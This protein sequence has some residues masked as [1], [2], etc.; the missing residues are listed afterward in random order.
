MKLIQLTDIHLTTPGE[1]IAGRD[2]NANFD[3]AL[4]HSLH[5]HPDAEAIVITGDLSDWGDEADYLRL[6]DRIAT[7]PVPVHLCIGNHD[8]RETFLRV[9]PD[10]ADPDGFA[11]RVAPLSRGAAVL[12]DTWGPE[13]HAG[14]FCERRAAWLDRQLAALPGPVWLFMHHNPAPTHIGPMDE[15][16]LLDADRF[17]AVIAAHRARIA[18][19]F[20]GHCHLPLSGS[21][22]G[23]PVSAPR[24]TNHASWANFGE[25]ALLSGSDLPEAY[26]VMMASDSAVTVHMV[27]FGYDGPIRTENTPDYADWD[28]AAMVR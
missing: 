22:R 8:D 5:H 2:P 21:F 23:V 18:H 4:A 6:R 13:T 19:I 1:T 3:R 12:I 10:H 9:F 27:E 20:H 15:I 28:R 7:L 25:A 14:H 17:G 24:G 16:M 26:A 11:Q